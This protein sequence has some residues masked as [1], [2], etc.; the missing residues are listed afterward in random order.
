M[1]FKLHAL[2]FLV[3]VLMVTGAPAHAEPRNRGAARDV[4]PADFPTSPVIDRQKDFWVS[5]F[6]KVDSDVGILHDGVLTQPV[7]EKFSLEGTG[8]RQRRRMISNKMRII[9]SNLQ[10]L[11][12]ALKANTDPD[13]EGKKLLALYGSEATYQRIREA[14]DNIRFQQGL[15]GKFQKGLI[16]SGLYFNK[17]RETLKAHGVPEDIAYLPHVES[18]YNYRAYSKMGAAGI[19]QFIRGTGK[20]YMNVGYEVDERLDPLVATHGAAELMRENYRQLGNWPLGITAYNHGWQNLRKIVAREGTS[21]LTH[22][23]LHYDGSKFKFASKNFY[24]EFLAAREVATHY[25]KYFG[26]LD[27]KDALKFQ[28]VKLPFYVDFQKAATLL[29]ISPDTLADLNPSLRRP[30]VVGTKY[31]PRGFPLR[32][33]EQNN[34]DQFIASV[35]QTNRFD[36]QKRIVEWVVT[37]GDT[38][39]GLGKEFGVSWQSIAEVNNLSRY[40]RLHPGQHLVIPPPGDKLVASARLKRKEER[41][42]R[43]ELVAARKETAKSQ[44]PAQSGNLA[45]QKAEGA[46]QFQDLGLHDY[47]PAAKEGEIRVAY[48]ETL[49][50]Y[51]TWSGSSIGHIRQLNSSGRTRSLRPGSPIAIPLS[52]S[53]ATDFTQARLEYHLGREEDFYSFYAITEVQKVKVGRGDTVWSL[54]QDNNVPMWLFYQQN[55]ELIHKPIHPG[56]LVNLPIIEEI[57]DLPEGKKAGGKAG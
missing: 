23:I 14:A 29:D 22:L 20:M 21:D 37:R 47:D 3:A 12:K 9:R 52:Q 51:A 17:I 13:E 10:N 55:P 28:E 2:Y 35:S 41:A 57:S 5:V 19:W 6:T 7:F 4:L 34:P 45:F 42:E 31:I 32:M 44:R 8:G 16:N 33:P 30:V 54:S 26:D 43:V 38:L 39:F 36:A 56:T 15:A 27:M 1:S 48:G 49:G 11:A 46:S 50:H 25:K 24:S 18:S 40:H 53:Q